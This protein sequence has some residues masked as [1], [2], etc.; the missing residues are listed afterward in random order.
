MQGGVSVNATVGEAYGSIWGT[1]F[2]YLNGERVIDPVSGR[3]VVD[4]K[5]QA[6]GNINPDWKAGLSHALSY[7]DFSL[8]FLLDFQKGGDV[9]S[10]DTWYGYGTGIYDITA[11]LNELGNPKRDP[12]TSGTDSGG[13]LLE[14]VNPDGGVNETRTHMYKYS[15]ALGWKSNLNAL[16]VYDASFVKLREVALS[17]K[18]PA[19]LF[20]KVPLKNVAISAIGRNL[21]IISKNIPYSDPEAGLSSGNLQGFQS[22]VMPST[23]NFGIN[24]NLNF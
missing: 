17:Y 22:G 5:P 16:H 18:I 15:N 10:L 2:T 14:G 9:F 19:K 21:W 20:G 23:R 12:V 7:K 1:N 24:I 8:S 11:G 13:I 6:I 4:G 3:Y